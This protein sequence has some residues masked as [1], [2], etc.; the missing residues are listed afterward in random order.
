MIFRIMDAHPV[1][2][3]SAVLLVSKSL[4]ITFD[5]LTILFG[6]YK[7]YV[8]PKMIYFYLF[9]LKLATIFSPPFITLEEHL[10]NSTGDFEPILR[11][12]FIKLIILL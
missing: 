1:H 4:Y 3:L 10:S 5:T 7:L 9:K 2:I 12:R 11:G 8:F 6:L